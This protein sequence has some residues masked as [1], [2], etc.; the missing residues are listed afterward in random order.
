MLDDPITELTRTDVALL[1]D[2]RDPR[3]HAA[4]EKFIAAI[5]ADDPGMVFPMVPGRGR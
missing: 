4:W 2:V 5:R 3:N 1:G